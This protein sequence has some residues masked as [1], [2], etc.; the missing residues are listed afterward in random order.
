M[1]T[2]NLRRASVS[3]KF[4]LDWRQVH[5]GVP[6]S[7]LDEFV[8]Y[9]RFEMADLQKVVISLRTLNRR[10]LR[11]KPLSLNE[12][13]RLARVARLFF[14][15]VKIFGGPAKAR[16]WLTCSNTHFE[17]RLPLSI[18]RTGVGGRAVEELLFQTENG[19]H[20]ETDRASATVPLG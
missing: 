4:D 15:A 11:Q 18:I 5:R 1:I 6:L 20:V 12:G 8:R 19:M 17:G 3:K 2:A 14:L 16:R 10:R 13:D 7:L 9:S